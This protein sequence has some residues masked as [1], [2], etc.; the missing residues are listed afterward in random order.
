MAWQSTPLAKTNYLKRQELRKTFE[1]ASN[2]FS[3][4]E[5]VATQ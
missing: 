3:L 2:H 4:D 1:V 5:E